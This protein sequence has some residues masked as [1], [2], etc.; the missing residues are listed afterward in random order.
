[1]SFNKKKKYKWILLPIETKNREFHA[2]VL[3]ACVAAEAGFAVVL[4]SLGDSKK[5]KWRYLPRGICLE[6]SIVKANNK[7][8]ALLRK[9]DNKVCAWCEE[10]LVLL[11]RKEYQQRRVC[12]ESVRQVEYFFAWGDYQADAI[13]EKIPSARSKVLICGNPRIDI[14]R[15]ELRS[16]F[17]EDVSTLV[18][19]YGDFVLVNTNFSLCN[20]VKGTEAVIKIFKQSGK[21]SS[22]EQESFYHEW[23]KFKSR[24]YQEFILLVRGLST[25]FP[26]LKVIIRPHPSEN[27]ESWKQ[28][29]KDFNNV[30]VV[31]EG[32]VIPW[33]RAAKVVIHNG[34]TTGLE[35]YLLD[36]PVIA[37]QPVTSPEFDFY[38]PNTVSSKATSIDAV[39]DT[40]RLYLQEGNGIDSSREKRTAVDLYLKGL[41]GKLASDHIVSVLEQIEVTPQ[42]FSPSLIRQITRR[43]FGTWSALKYY[44]RNIKDRLVIVHDTGNTGSSQTL[45]EIQKKYTEQ[46][47]PGMS[48]EEV[49]I[50]VE[51]LQN[52]SGRFQTVKVVEVDKN[53]YVIGAWD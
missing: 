31:H 50:T 18:K 38:L 9:F 11:S 42:S 26:D 21:I 45:H 34:C 19:H 8:F 3:L 33:L 22:K 39:I 36:R 7:K 4:W 23:I 47:F 25:A 10:G 43:L 5:Q 51:K 53:S 16:V 12:E 48:L 46:K 49:Q 52:A 24:L 17:D 41:E 15:S 37:F 1:M 29:A 13:I 2:K 6:K 44:I 35:G 28:T 27:F 32:N 14:L 40:V 30:H 20:H